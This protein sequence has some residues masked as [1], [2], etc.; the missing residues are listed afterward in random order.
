MPCNATETGRRAHDR[1]IIDDGRSA[2]C[3]KQRAGTS[4]H[5]HGVPA[6]PLVTPSEFTNWPAVG[7]SRRH[8][9][10]FTALRVGC[11]FRFSRFR[12]LK[13]PAD[14]AYQKVVDLAMT[15]HGRCLFIR[16]VEVQ[17]MFCALTQQFAPVSFKVLNQI[18]PLHG[19]V[20]SKGSLETSLPTIERSASSRFASSTM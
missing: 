3:D 2:G 7:T 8:T 5:R 14:L 10:Q 12:N 9:S 11:R 20:R 16:R 17:R 6:L 18:S 4:N 19:D 13:I 1:P 15:W